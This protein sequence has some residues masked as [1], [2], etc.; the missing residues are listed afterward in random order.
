MRDDSVVEAGAWV[1]LDEPISLSIVDDTA[2]ASEVETALRSEADLHVSV[3]TDPNDVLDALETDSTAVDCVVTGYDL[4]GTTGVELVSHVRA[5]DAELPV[6]LVTD[7]GSEAIASEAI[8]AGVTDYLSKQETARQPR[9]VVKRIRDAVDRRRAH[10]DRE[11]HL[12]AIETATEGISHLDEDGR[13]LYV[14][15]AYATLYGYDRADLLGE[16]WERLYRPADVEEV[17]EE[18][19]PEV[20]ET[21]SWSGYTTGRRADGSTFVEDHNLALTA[22]GTLVCTVHDVD[23]RDARAA[24]IEERLFVDRAT[25]L[26]SDV[27]YVVD[28]EGR[29]AWYNE[30][31]PAVSGY[32]PSAIDEMSVQEFFPHTER[33][34]IEAALDAVLA[35][36]SVVVETAIETAADERV[37]FE[38]TGDQLRD[39]DGTLVGVIGVGRDISARRARERKLRALNETGQ[40][41]MGGETQAAVAE[42][43]VEAA[44]DV[45]GLGANAIHLYDEETGGLVPV[46]QTESGGELLPDP[47]TLEPGSSIAGR[48]F[49]S[50]DS[51]ASDDV[52]ADPDVLNP[53]TS[54]ESEV[55]LPLGEYG[56]LIAASETPHAFDDEDVVLGEILAGS[57]EAALEAVERTEQLAARQRQLTAQNDRLEEFASVVSHDLR[58]PLQVASGQV[59]LARETGA[60][61]DALG[62][63]IAALDRMDALIDDLLTL[64]RQGETIGS[65]EPVVLDHLARQCWGTVDTPAATIRCDSDLV[66]RADRSRLRQLLE[67]LLHNAVEH[68]RPIEPSDTR[69]MTSEGDAS[70]TVTVGATEDGF[71]VADDGRGIP[72]DDRDRIFETGYTTSS[73]GT[74]F[75]MGIVRQVVDAHGWSIEVTE[76]AGGGARFDVTGVEILE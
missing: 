19:L 46:A 58:N 29:L 51:Y 44:R 14:N 67:N 72:P 37:P 43:G 4:P 8:S 10:R 60:D 75:G 74:G 27:L 25:D 52:R 76:S 20:Y 12:T 6:I 15:E 40:E 24:E 3:E 63:A 28:E 53:A 34:R 9:T 1:G 62:E 71:F 32:E 69:W 56:V 38:F 17:R 70:L 18:I 5:I 54:I 50:G 64:S 45:L 68:G 36:D 22:D 26:L 55:F 21:G 57:I 65:L 33:G 73:D 48:V 59:E 7:A 16:S 42:I 2:V 61:S 30:R 31:L 13:F 35:G 47:P 11:R 41:L 49:E 39:G 23:A 66:V